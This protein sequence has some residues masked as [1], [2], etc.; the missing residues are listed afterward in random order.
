MNE[1]IKNMEKAVPLNLR[2]LV[3]YDSGKVAS[4]TLAQQPKVGMTLFVFDGNEEISTHTAP[5]DAFVQILEGQAEITIAGTVH[6]MAEG[7]A[8]V[9]PAG[10]PHSVR[11]VTQFKMLLTVVK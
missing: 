5:G 3:G 6:Q 1:L 11:A 8:I 9:M 2:G 10:I 4:L 7:Q